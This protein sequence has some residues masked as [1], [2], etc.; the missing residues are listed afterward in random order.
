MN[1][2]FQTTNRYREQFLFAVGIKAVKTSKTEDFMTCWYYT[3]T[4]RLERAVVA[5]GE[6]VSTP[7]TAA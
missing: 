4:P 7:N 2:M 1:D 3:R 6:I 5:Y